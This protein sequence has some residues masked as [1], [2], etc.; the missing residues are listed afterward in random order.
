[1]EEKARPIE[2]A[3]EFLGE[4]LA[5]S[6]HVILAEGRRECAGSSQKRKGQDKIIV[7]ER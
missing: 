6:S 4:I 1:M 2:P 3:V 7:L 5:C